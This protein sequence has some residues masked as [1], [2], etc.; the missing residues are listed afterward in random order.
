MIPLLIK[1]L[2]QLVT[3]NNT[4]LVIY[5][6]L[7]IFVLF[8]IQSTLNL[9]IQYVV[10]QV[11]KSIKY[12]LCRSILNKLD[13]LSTSYYQQHRATKIHT[14][15]IQDSLR[16]DNAN[17]IILMKFVSSVI[18]ALPLLLFL[19]IVYT[20]L[21]LILLTC[22]IPASTITL[23]F[24][25]RLRN[26]LLTFFT[27][28]LEFSKKTLFLIQMRNLIRWHTAEAQEHTRKNEVLAR[29]QKADFAKAWESAFYKELQ[30]LL[31]VCIVG[32]ITMS[33]IFMKSYS[34]V[35][36]LFAFI[37][38]MR[39]LI[40]YI[41]NIF[42]SFPQ[43]INARESWR[44]IHQLLNEKNVE[45]Y[46]GNQ[47]IDIQQGIVVKSLV[48]SYKEKMIFDKLNFSVA[49]GDSIVIVGGNGTGKSTIFYLLL[50]LY[51]PQSGGIYVDEVSYDQIDIYHLRQQISIVPQET[52]ILPGTIYE[53]ITYGTNANLAE[54][55]NAAQLATAEEFIMD[56]PKNYETLIGEEGIFL[57]GGQKQRLSIAR[58]LLRKPKVLLLDEPDNYLE[59]ESLQRILANI[60]TVISDIIVIVITHSDEVAQNFSKVY[61]LTNGKLE[62]LK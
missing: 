17:N 29:C 40:Q 12:D 14:W 22:V 43:I 34:N 30:Q 25:N 60:S 6:S 11:T 26:K 2:V 20:K 15:I 28:Y 7:F 33:V 42:L 49:L 46:N 9:Y 10:L 56:F 36:N 58:A 8:V 19:V 27:S 16:L 21:L 48:F 41:K 38:A 37:I 23:F 3:Q 45:P 31:F 35:G 52:M 18:I 55:K 1:N 13:N 44:I 51:K 39:F 24:H 61:V 59:Q 4:R 54:V 47:R 5:Q 57:S 50:G 32:L 53:N 62:K